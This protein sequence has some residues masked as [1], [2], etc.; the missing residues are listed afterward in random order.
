M[1][2]YQYI[3]NVLLQ[4]IFG[5]LLADL[6]GGLFHWFE[7]TYLDYCID[8]PILSNIAKD[9]EM[10]HYFPRGI[11]A[12]SDIESMIYTFPLCI[13]I[14]V[15]LWIFFNKFVRHN[16]IFVLSFLFFTLI[17]NILHKYSHMR[18][19][20][21]NVIIR[22]LQ[23]YKILCSH[24]YHRLHHN[25]VSEKYCVLTEFNNYYLDTFYI[26]RIFEYLIIIF[27][28]VHPSRKPK[29]EDYYK[30]HTDIHEKS[31]LECP[32]KPTKQIMDDLFK[33]LAEYK[34]C[35]V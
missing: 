19:C 14:F 32:D 25:N 22:T 20:E 30:I 13:F 16:Y 10:H 3:F 27:T 28:G 8:I 29:Y 18:D 7:D 4:I 11:I 15:F 35:S 5:F 12:Y 24:E 2:K 9:N 1:V 26:W 33:K 34:N 21:K 6:E 17:M 31:K 23:R